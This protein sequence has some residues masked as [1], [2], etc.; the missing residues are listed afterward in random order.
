MAVPNSESAESLQHAP[1]SPS[2]VC[3]TFGIVFYYSKYPAHSPEKAASWSELRSKNTDSGTVSQF[4]ALIEEVGDVEPELKPSVFF[5]EM[6]GVGESQIYWIIP[7]QLIRVRKA[8]SQAAAIEDVSIDG[9]VFISVRGAGR[10]RVTLIMIQEDPVVASESKLV[11]AEKE[12]AGN[13]IFAGSAFE[14]EIGIGAKAS[15]GVVRRNLGAI[16]ISFGIVKR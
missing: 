5:R 1:S 2:G 12:L 9:S 3:R 8:A 13:N 14:T 10:N 15:L 4:V 6:K 16:L 11:R 7:R